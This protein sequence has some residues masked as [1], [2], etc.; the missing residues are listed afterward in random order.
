MEWKMIEGIDYCFIYPKDD[1]TAVHMKLVDIQ[2]QFLM[3]D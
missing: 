2:L 1:G 3:L